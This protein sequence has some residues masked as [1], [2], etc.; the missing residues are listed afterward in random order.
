MA[1]P[2][3]PKTTSTP[4][5]SRLLMRACAPVSCT[6]FLCNLDKEKGLPFWE[7]SGVRQCV[8]TGAWRLLLP[9]EWSHEKSRLQYSHPLG[10]TQHVD[11]EVTPLLAARW[12]DWA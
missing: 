9:R 11:L 5:I 6:M 8:T 12:T 2:G 3:R 7:A 4:S 10:P 1:P